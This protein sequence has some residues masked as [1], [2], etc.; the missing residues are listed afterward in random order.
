MAFDPKRSCLPCSN[1][2]CNVVWVAATSP[3]SNDD[4][5]HDEG[6]GEGGE[7]GRDDGARAQQESVLVVAAAWGL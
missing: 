3:G 7:A 1:R 6:E 5:D 2:R 4:N